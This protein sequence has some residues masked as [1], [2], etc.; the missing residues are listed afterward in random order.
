MRAIPFPQWMRRAMF[1]TAA[2][3]I[4]VA[5]AFLPAAQSL[6]EL[7]GMPD[8]HP[9]YLLTVGMFILLFGIVYLRMAIAGAGDRFIVAWSAAG[10]LGFFALNVHLWRLG[11]LPLRAPV[12]ASAD[13]I[14][15][16]LFF[17]WLLT[18]RA[19]ATIA[20]DPLSAAP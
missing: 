5:A 17:S 11:E 13:L 14:F 19:P 7:A 4:S 15:A 12:L 9:F 18:A 16:G 2:M 8:A 10:K 1:A 6:R 20:R 3:N